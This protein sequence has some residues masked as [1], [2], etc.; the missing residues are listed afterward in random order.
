MFR[1]KFRVVQ[2]LLT[3]A[4]PEF[5]ARSSTV[6]C[7]RSAVYTL[8]TEVAVYIYGSNLPSLPK[9]MTNLCVPLEISAHNPC[10]MKS[11]LIISAR[12]SSHKY[13]PQGVTDCRTYANVR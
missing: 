1:V 6:H 13:A 11:L 4:A 12:D 10:D 5:E 9:Q 2:R 7:V 3:P 8:L